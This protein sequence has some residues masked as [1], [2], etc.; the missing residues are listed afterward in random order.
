MSK[1]NCTDCPHKS[2]TCMQCL[3]LRD[4]ITDQRITRLF[5]FSVGFLMA[6]I[7]FFLSHFN[8]QNLFE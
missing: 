5:W 6:V 1:N 2:T 8:I 7:A 4:E 3:E